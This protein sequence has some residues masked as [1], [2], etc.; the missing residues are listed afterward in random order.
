MAVLEAILGTARVRE[1]KGYSLSMII[2]LVFSLLAPS[3]TFSASII[4]SRL[5]LFVMASHS[6]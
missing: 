1:H 2:L 5:E 3:P 6:M 4:T